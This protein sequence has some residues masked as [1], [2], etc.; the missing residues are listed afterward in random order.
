MNRP[1]DQYI[2]I[3][4]Q[5]SVTRHVNYRHVKWLTFRMEFFSF[6]YFSLWGS[7]IEDVRSWRVTN[8]DWD[9][10][11]TLI[12][13]G[14]KM[15]CESE[16]TGGP[17]SSQW[18][19]IGLR[20]RKGFRGWGCQRSQLPLSQDNPVFGPSVGLKSVGWVVGCEVFD[21]SW[22]RWRSLRHNSSGILGEMTKTGTEEWGWEQ[23]RTVSAVILRKLYV[24]CLKSYS[25][26]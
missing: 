5:F 17:W 22:H 2:Y 19:G 6:I 1:Y 20:T 8:K 3:Y 16:P 21:K 9:L 12:S 13:V 24:Q 18:I 15:T 4:R 26:F 10:W 14:W 7:F 11:G 25:S 23:R